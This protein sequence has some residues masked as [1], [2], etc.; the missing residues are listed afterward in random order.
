MHDPTRI[1]PLLALAVPLLAAACVAEPEGEAADGE[2]LFGLTD[3]DVS[4]I[5]E[6]YL[7]EQDLELTRAQLTAPF[8]CAH[9]GDLCQQVGRES[10][11]EITRWQV[12]Q[13]LAGATMDEIQAELDI[14]I[15]EASAQRRARE[16]ALPDHE[17][18]GQQFRGSGAWATRTKGDYRL[19]VRNGV[20]SPLFGNRIAYTESKL[21]HQ[22]WTGIWWAV[23][24]T[25]ICANTGLNEQTLHPF[26]YI[27]HTLDILVEAKDPAKQCVVGQSSFE[28]QTTH[29]RLVASES[30][31]P[32]IFVRGCGSG[33]VNGI[34]LG[35][36][37]DEYMETF[38]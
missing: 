4:Y 27:S 11:I 19:R 9:F 22:D 32:E 16:A 37:A 21:Q 24:G 25:E 20:S 14:L 8:A 28:Q 13:A 34:N 5:H 15:P 1:L 6:N 26:S 35:I 10:A 30:W 12:E 31:I 36:C 33:V 3:E 2:L 7:A 29:V 18:E 23:S 17:V 38:W